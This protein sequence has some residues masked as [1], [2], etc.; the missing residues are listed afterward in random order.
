M[1]PTRESWNGCRFDPGGSSG[2]YESWFQRANHPTR[3]L[4]FWIRYT[5]FAPIDRH[6]DAIGQLW[7]VYSDGERRRIVAV[8]QE[9]PLGLCAFSSSGLDVRIGG[10][11]LDASALEGTC[12]TG[13][14]DV[15]WS[16]GYDSPQDPLLLLPQALYAGGFPK[17]KALVGSP[18]AR[19][20]G[21]LEVDAER[22]D[23]DGWIGSQNHNWGSRHTD[24]YAWGQVAGFD[25]D[26]DA[27]LE[28]STAR[29][30]VGP[31]RTPP[32]TLIVLRLDGEELRLN[33]LARAIRARGHYEPF[34][35]SFETANATTH[36]AGTIAAPAW[37]FAALPYANPPGGLKT[38]LNSK[39]AR[40]DLTVTRKGQLRTFSTAHRAAFEIVTDSAAPSGVTKL[41]SSQAAR[42]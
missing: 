36:I 16:L 20:V 10:A 8:L 31:I 21:H 26:P 35:W 33:T 41:A 29:V 30:R 22:I 27:F 19:F 2:H 6:A 12:R 25:D 3:P 14:H 7:A 34:H 13:E 11:R 38:C 32:M 17:A 18:G 42:A 40:C 9:Y 15:S 39:L 24:A 1:E 5:I 28:L 23:I 4:A 37:S